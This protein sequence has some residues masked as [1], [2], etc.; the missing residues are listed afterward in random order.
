MG[1]VSWLDSDWLN[2]VCAPCVLFPSA[3]CLHDSSTRLHVYQSVVHSSL[4]L[5]SIS[6]DRY[7]AVCLC[8]HCGGHLGWFQFEVIMN[9]AAMNIHVQGYV[10]IYFHF[11]WENTCEWDSWITW[12]VYI[13]LYKKTPNKT[14][15][16]IVL[17]VPFTF[18]ST[19]YESCLCQHLVFSIFYILGG[20]AS[21]SY[22]WEVFLYLTFSLIHWNSL[23]LNGSACT[24][25]NLQQM[26]T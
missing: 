23:L 18:S 5:S 17:I 16:P 9:K 4:L 11:V 21:F 12:Y 25:S 20:V 3:H 10:D 26:V 1:S 22:L 13:S 19:S 8:T 24:V 2:I 7:S 15:P 6:I 14:N